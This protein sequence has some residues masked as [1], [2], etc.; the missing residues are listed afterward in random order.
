MSRIYWWG[1]PTTADVPGQRP[2]FYQD[3]CFCVRYTDLPGSLR[4][5]N[6]GPEH[7]DPPA[8]IH[9]QMGLQGRNKGRNKGNKG[10]VWVGGCSFKSS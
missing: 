6:L 3:G 5:V 7:T 1:T 2:R 9:A 4:P 10:R 8:R